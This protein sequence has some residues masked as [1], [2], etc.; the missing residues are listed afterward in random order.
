[1]LGLSI[2]GMLREN[3]NVSAVLRLN[4]ILEREALLLAQ[5]GYG[6]KS[7]EVSAFPCHSA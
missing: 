7:L 5:V 2:L 3:K 6:T 1:M 4:I